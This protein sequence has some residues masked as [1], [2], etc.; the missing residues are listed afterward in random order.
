M[1]KCGLNG[2]PLTKYVMTRDGQH[3]LLIDGFRHADAVMAA[4]R[5]GSEGSLKTVEYL[6]THAHSD[7]YTGLKPSWNYG[8]IYCS[9]VT[10]RLI[11]HLIGIDPVWLEPLAMEN[12]TTLPSGTQVTLVDANHCPGA[13]MFTI[14]LPDGQKIL[15]TG[16][17]RFAEWMSKCPIVRNFQ[18]CDLLYLDTTYCDKKHRFPPQEKAVEFISST[19]QKYLQEDC[20]CKE[21][22]RHKST[23]KHQRL[24]LI[25]TYVIGKERI[26]KEIASKCN[27]PVYASER[28]SSVLASLEDILPKGLITNDPESTPVHLVPWNGF[29]GETW[30]FFR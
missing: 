3:A 22:D 19:I 17:F 4:Q 10:A 20:Q 26:F 16:D 14:V 23:G 24:Y 13:V 2:I 7:H 21:R 6:L 28:K 27:V 25:S 9:D 12:T 18:G 8:K 11:V 30:P 1:A 15:H 29:L 5:E